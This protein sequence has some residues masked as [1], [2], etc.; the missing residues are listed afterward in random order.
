VLARPTACGKTV[1]GLGAGHERADTQPRDGRLALVQQPDLLLEGQPADQIVD[2]LGQW[3][4]RLPEHRR[5]GVAHADQG[6]VA[7]TVV[8]EAL[9]RTGHRR[10]PPFRSASTTHL[11]KAVVPARIR[12]VE[13]RR[14]EPASH[15]PRPPSRASMAG[16]IS[17]QQRPGLSAASLN[18]DR[19]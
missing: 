11:K 15:A 18:D 13:A 12:C 2:P 7:I 19:G 17:F 10:H 16:S 5:V 3:A 8:V 9:R 1:Q 6:T 4:F 14:Q